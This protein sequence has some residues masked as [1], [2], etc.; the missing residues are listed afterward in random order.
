LKPP[1][2][3]VCKIVWGVI[4]PL[5][6]N[7]YLNELDRFAEDTLI[8]TYTKGRRR[9]D[10]PEYTNLRTQIEAAQR[11]EAIDEVKRLKRE[12][13]KLMAVAPCD[14]DYRRLRYIRYADDCA[15]GN[16]CSR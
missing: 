8:P 14:P 6:C 10:N 11:R 15:P 1:S 3:A 5:L 4:S 2:G 9:I 7:I 12:R 13:R 16:V